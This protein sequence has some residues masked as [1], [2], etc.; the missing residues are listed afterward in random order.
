MIVPTLINNLN[1]ATFI[2]SFVTIITNPL[3]LILP[4]TW[5]MTKLHPLQ[6]IIPYVQH[7][8][9]GKQQMLQYFLTPA[10]TTIIIVNETK[11]VQPL[12]LSNSIMTRNPKS[13]DISRSCNIS[14]HNL[15]PIDLMCMLFKIQV[16][17]TIFESWIVQHIV[18][19]LR[20]SYFLP[21]L[22]NGLRIQE[23]D[24]LIGSIITL[25]CLIQ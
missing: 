23:H 12:L 2:N 15:P 24:L 16:H 10:K 14:L 11:H 20:M 13:E 25:F 9:T 19:G 7:I 8:C 5:T 22:Q 18:P 1:K 6:N 4:P 3:Q 17:L 21:L